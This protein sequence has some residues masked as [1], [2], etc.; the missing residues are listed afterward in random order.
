[1]MYK[2]AHMLDG[3]CLCVCIIYSNNNVRTNHTVNN[4][5]HLFSSYMYYVFI[6]TFVFSSSSSFLSLSFSF[7]LIRQS[8]TH[9]LANYFCYWCCQ[10]WGIRD[11]SSS[12]VD[13]ILQCTQD[14]EVTPAD[15]VVVW[16]LCNFD[17]SFVCG[18]GRPIVVFC[19]WF[20]WDPA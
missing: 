10:S 19:V 6:S 13:S 3:L 9:L 1:M 14:G 11:S 5:H 4:Y 18:I 15:C 17:V 7:Q 2:I 8:F 20:K 12:R 16:T